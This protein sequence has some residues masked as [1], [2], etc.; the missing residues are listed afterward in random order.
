MH[1]QAPGVRCQQIAARDDAGDA[2][3][4][5]R[6]RDNQAPDIG[7]GHVIGCVA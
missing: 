2:Q 3:H 6:D 5:W 4:L 7:A 1:A